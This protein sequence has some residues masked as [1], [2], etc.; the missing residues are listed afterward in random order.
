MK[1]KEKIKENRFEKNLKLKEKFYK[2]EKKLPTIMEEEAS[3]KIEIFEELK[4]HNSQSHISDIL[5]PDNQ[6]DCEVKVMVSSRGK[7][8]SHESEEVIRVSYNIGECFSTDKDN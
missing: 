3:S 5:V 7:R 6:G 2:S 8:T 4:D 1:R